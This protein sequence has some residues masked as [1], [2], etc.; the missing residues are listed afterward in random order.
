MSM[1]FV[2]NKGV[3][4]CK[5]PKFSVCLGSAPRE[6]YLDGGCQGGPQRQ[7]LITDMDH[8][9]GDNEDLALAAGRS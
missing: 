8:K 5:D 1:S 3:L 2:V 4:Q 9:P 6:P 7:A